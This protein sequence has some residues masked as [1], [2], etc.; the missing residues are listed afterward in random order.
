MYLR[1]HFCWVDIN[2][3]R[4]SIQSLDFSV[5]Q[6]SCAGPMLYTV[7]AS[8]LQYKISK[9]MDL[10]G[11]ADDHLV[12]KSFNPNDR[13]DELR[14]IELLKSSLENINSWMSSNR[15]QMNTSKMKFMM[16]G[17]RKQL[18]K[19]VANHIEVCNNTV[20]KVKSSDYWGYGLIAT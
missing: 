7:Y 14:T 3:A 1:P 17:S 9:G 2:G 10:N 18:S 12:N 11:V 15:L 19:C 6:E 16:I 5:P 20:E 4:S 13:N 8:T